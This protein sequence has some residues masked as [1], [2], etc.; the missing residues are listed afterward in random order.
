MLL[1]TGNVNEELQEQNLRKVPFL[2]KD[3]DIIGYGFSCQ[4]G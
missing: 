1:T 2:I 4:I 3:G